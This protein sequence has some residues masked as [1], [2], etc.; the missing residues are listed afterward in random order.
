MFSL[1][2]D[3]WWSA[4]EETSALPFIEN[5]GVKLSTPEDRMFRLTLASLT[6]GITIHDAGL[7]ERLRR[8]SYQAQQFEH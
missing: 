2:N 6:T 1:N 3:L 4:N 7:G 8:L 5:S